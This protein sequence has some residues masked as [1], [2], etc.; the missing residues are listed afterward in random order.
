MPDLRRAHKT[1]NHL[2]LARIENRHIHVLA[3]DG[4]EMTGL[5][6][7]NVLQSSDLVRSTQV[8]TR[9]PEA[10]NQGNEPDIPAFP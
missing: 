8:S 3:R 10:H 2:L 5:H 6:E 9:H 4:A 1:M 7:A